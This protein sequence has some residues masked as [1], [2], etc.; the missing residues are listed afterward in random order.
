MK[1][2]LKSFTVV[3]NFEKTNSVMKNCNLPQVS[4]HKYSSF[5]FASG[6]AA[7]ASILT[8]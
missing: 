7:H 5:D 3:Y 6:I 2:I 4:H 1:K 8:I